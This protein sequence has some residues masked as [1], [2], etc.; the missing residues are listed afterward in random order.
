MKESSG[1][2]IAR[3]V[4]SYDLGR[5][6]RELRLRKKI[7]LADLA[8]HTGL[9]SSMLSQLETGKLIPTL[10]T[11]AR[12]AMVF[13]VGLEHFFGTKRNKRRFAVVR[14]QE[15]IRFPERADAPNPSYFFEC[16]AFATQGKVFETYLAEFPVQSA[17][18]GTPHQ[19]DGAEFVHVLEGTLVIG[20]EDEDQE[21]HTGDSAYFDPAEPHTYRATGKHPARAIVITS[22]PRN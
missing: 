1:E 7:A 6:L 9:S 20:F 21:L 5:K 8:R 3:W 10:P 13:D 11:L 15:R 12:I 16:L 18:T 22:P 17:D 4:G 19:H 2:T 14:R